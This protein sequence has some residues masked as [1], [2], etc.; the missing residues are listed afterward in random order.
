MDATLVN[1]VWTRLPGSL[2]RNGLLEQNTH[3]AGLRTY[4]WSAEN[5]GP[6]DASKPHI[7]TD[8]YWLTVLNIYKQEV[9][10]SIRD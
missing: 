10:I 5:V 7:N 1:M 9:A 6:M 8:N 4:D 3:G 2:V